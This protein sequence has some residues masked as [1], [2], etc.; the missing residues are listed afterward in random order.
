M[1]KSVD[2]EIHIDHVSRVRRSP[3]P[4]AERVVEVACLVIPGRVLD[5]Q[6]IV[7]Q[8]FGAGLRVHVEDGGCLG[9]AWDSVGGSMVPGMVCGESDD[10]R[11]VGCQGP[12]FGTELEGEFREEGEGVGSV[13]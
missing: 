13:G 8:S 11:L 3:D 10:A 2:V 9:L 1:Q 6:G 7:L 4:A 12:Y 5:A